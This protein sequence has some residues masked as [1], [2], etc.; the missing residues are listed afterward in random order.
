VGNAPASEELWRDGYLHTQDVARIDPDGYVQIT[1]RTKDII[2]TGGE[3]LSSIQIED[4]VS[5][6]PEVAAVAV[7]AVR[8][9]KW[10][11]RPH[12]LVVP[13]PGHAESLTGDAIRAWIAAAATA[14][15]IPRY[16]VPERVTF[17]DSLAR[18]SVGKIN[19]RALREQ[20]G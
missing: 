4:I 16:A 19:K 14:G 7:I 3:W 18:T 13:R 12:V 15:T 8:D 6:H 10:G 2:K 5:R 1:D 17:V 9:A 11:E 20:Y